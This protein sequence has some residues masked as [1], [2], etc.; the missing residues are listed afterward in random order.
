MII[1]NAITLRVRLAMVISKRFNCAYYELEA[2]MYSRD[3]DE[4]AIAFRM[5]ATVLLILLLHQ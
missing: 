3:N 5:K 1:Q 4:L 2:C